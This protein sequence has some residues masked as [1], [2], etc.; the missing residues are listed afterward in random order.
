MAGTGAASRGERVEPVGRATIRSVSKPRTPGG[1]PSASV[2]VVQELERLRPLLGAPHHGRLVQL[3]EAL[4]SRGCVPVAVAIAKLFPSS[5]VATGNKALARLRARLAEAARASKSELALQVP[6]ARSPGASLRELWFTGAPAP[7]RHVVIVNQG[8]SPLGYDVPFDVQRIAVTLSSVA[9]P[10]THDVYF[11]PTYSRLGRTGKQL[12]RPRLVP[13]VLPGT[14]AFLDYHLINP[15]TVYIDFMKTRLDFRNRG[16]A[17]A[18][19]DHIYA[20]YKNADWVIWGK[21][22]HPHA[23][24]LYKARRSLESGPSSHGRINF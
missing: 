3:A 24:K 1:A 17:R 7:H 16:F 21:I 15:K 8:I 23:A 5:S 6:R 2:D 18:L 22:M 14:V 13:G 20:E 4:D 10:S 9:D 12:Q 19:V 11:S